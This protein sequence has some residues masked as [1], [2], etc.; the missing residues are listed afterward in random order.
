MVR[1]ILCFMED[2]KIVG[3]HFKSSLRMGHSWKLIRY[4][5]SSQVREKGIE[6]VRSAVVGYSGKGPCAF[7]ICLE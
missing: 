7:C 3:I 5:F 2:Q 1:S 4:V 6:V